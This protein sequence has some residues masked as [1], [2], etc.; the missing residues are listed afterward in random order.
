MIHTSLARNCVVFLLLCELTQSDID[1]SQKFDSHKWPT[2]L[3][4]EVKGKTV[5]FRGMFVWI[6]VF[7]FYNIFLPICIL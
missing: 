1:G 2:V 6:I 4:D 7:Y 5:Q 3:V